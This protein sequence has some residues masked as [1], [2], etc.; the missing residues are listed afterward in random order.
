MATKQERL[1]FSR[2]R[3]ITDL[4]CQT[5]AINEFNEKTD[6]AVVIS[7]KDALEELWAE[8]KANTQQLESLRD[9]AGTDEF[10]AESSATRELYLAAATKV[11]KFMP[12]QAD[13]MQQSVIMFR[14]TYTTVLETHNV[15]EPQ[16]Q[17]T[18]NETNGTE[19]AAFS[20]PRALNTQRTGVLQANIKL[21]PLQ[22][23]PFI[24]DRIDWP[25]FKALCQATFTAIM[26]DSNRFISKKPPD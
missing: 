14:P 19:R 20:T 24:G 16:I 26:D 1:I 3:I 9:W 2:K 10:I 11:L 22:I 6:Y 18:G 7:R 25:E 4:T 5:S 21:P 17:E 15:H 13:A 23:K 8:F 12:E